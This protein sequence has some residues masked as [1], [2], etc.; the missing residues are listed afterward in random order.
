[1]NLDGMGRW[2]RLPTPTLWDQSA[3]YVVPIFPPPPIVLHGRCI[4]SITPNFTAPRPSSSDEIFV[5]IGDTLTWSVSFY[6]YD[7]IVLT[8]LVA[9]VTIDYQTRNGPASLILP[10]TTTGFLRTT[11]WTVDVSTIEVSTARWTIE[12]NNLNVLVRGKIQIFDRFA[13]PIRNS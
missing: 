4:Y 13:K 11:S 5:K 6:L 7:L 8:S 2:T 1:M 10:L 12:Q 3:S 9:T